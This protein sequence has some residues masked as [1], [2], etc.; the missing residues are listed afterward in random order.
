[1]FSIQSQFRFANA[2]KAFRSRV[3][4]ISVTFQLDGSKLKGEVVDVGERG[5]GA[6]LSEPIIPGTK[7]N[8]EVTT[9]LGVVSAVGLI[10]YC[11]SN[12]NGTYRAGVE[13]VDMGRLDKPRWLRYVSEL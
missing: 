8:S 2:I 4:G 7:L 1:R 12:P 9:S 3:K 6:I 10:R 11:N 13:L 5:F